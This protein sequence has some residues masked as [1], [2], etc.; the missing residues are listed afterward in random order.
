MSKKTI[1]FTVPLATGPNSSERR[2]P[3]A[4]EPI[5]RFIDA[6]RWVNQDHHSSRDSPTPST[7][8]V[9]ERPISVTLPDDLD[10]FDVVNVTV[11]AYLAACIWTLNTSQKWLRA[12]M[13]RMP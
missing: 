9:A 10:W 3:G 11:L 4:S 13:G 5:K 7:R 12:V 6:E 1:P 8:D 2:G